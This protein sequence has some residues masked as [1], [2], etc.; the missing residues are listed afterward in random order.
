MSKTRFRWWSYVKNVI[1]H[2]PILEQEYEAL[3]EQS[4]TASMTGMPRRSGVSRGTEEIAIREL[5]DQDQREYEAVKRAIETTKGLRTGTDRMKLI[6]MVFW[7]RSHTLEGAAFN[8]HCSYRTAVRYH[9]DFIILVAKNMGFLDR[10]KREEEKV[11]I[12]TP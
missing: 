4:V 9:S 8:V 3:H 12:K 5:P 1:R 7:K 2:Y 10:R 11:G 6:S